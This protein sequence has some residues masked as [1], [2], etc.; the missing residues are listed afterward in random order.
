MGLGLMMLLVVAVTGLA[1]SVGRSSAP[2]PAPEPKRFG[3]NQ[4][5]AALK[6]VQAGGAVVA[7]SILGVV[8]GVLGYENA[9]AED[10]EEEVNNLAVA[11]ERRNGKASANE[12]KIAALN[13]E[14]ERLLAASDNA[15][16][17]TAQLRE[18]AEVFRG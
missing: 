14:I 13:A 12:D 7:Q 6:Y 9:V 10:V 18:I 1:Y 16:K 11:T 8:V 5:E 3:L 15:N 4:A 17:R 2:T